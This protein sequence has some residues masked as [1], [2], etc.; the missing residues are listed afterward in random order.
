MKRL[1]QPESQLQEV[2][3]YLIKRIYID[4]RQM[5][6]SVGVLNLPEA[7][8][9]LRKNYGLTINTSK[10]KFVNKFGLKKTYGQYS[11]EHKKEASD[12]YRKL[13]DKQRKLQI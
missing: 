11:L 13:Q 4:R 1:S 10:V 2:L 5:I 3:Y 7:I 8:R 12:I 9:K 6:L